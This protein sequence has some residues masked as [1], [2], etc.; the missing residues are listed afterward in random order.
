MVQGDYENYDAKL[1]Q[2]L[3]RNPGKTAAHWQ[4]EKTLR[5]LAD[6]AATHATLGTSLKK[7]EDASEPS[8]RRFR[9]LMGVTASTRIVDYGC[10][11][12]RIGAPLIRDQDLGCYFGVEPVA[13]YL[14]IAR[15]MY[16]SLIDDKGARLMALSER[17]VAEAAAFSPDVVLSTAVA[18]HVPPWDA[19]SYFGNLAK[20]AHRPGARVFFDAVISATPFRYKNLSWAWPRD[21]FV[22][23]LPDF[24]LVDSHAPVQREKIGQAVESA[25]LEFRRR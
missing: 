22:K 25:V 4:G 3:K 5:K 14:D 23:A 18:F 2:W 12:L 24:D 8:Y 15:R 20:I 13:G 10:G 19:P 21:Y 16:G 9:R 7:G 11:T 17:A 6:P 1:A